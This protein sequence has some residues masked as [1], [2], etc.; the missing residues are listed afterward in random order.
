M[1][2]RKLE[3]GSRESAAGADSD[4]S[5]AIRAPK[6][7]L[8]AIYVF[9]LHFVCLLLRFRVSLDVCT[10]TN[11]DFSSFHSLDTTCNSL[12]HTLTAKT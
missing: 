4:S 6:P 12:T 11:Y 5:A 10:D 8:V 3:A 2:A 7:E 9:Q 1:R